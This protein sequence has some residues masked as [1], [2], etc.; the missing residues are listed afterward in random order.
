ML[1]FRAIVGFTLIELLI[2]ILLM[3]LSVS[4][5]GPSLFNQ[6][7]KSKKEV[8]IAQIEKQLRYISQ[9]AFYSRTIHSVLFSGKQM[10][11]FERAPLSSQWQ[12]LL[13]NRDDVTLEALLE[14]AELV[15]QFDDVFFQ[16][17]YVQFNQMGMP[18][19]DIVRVVLNEEESQLVL[20]KVF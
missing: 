10:F 17:T 15:R 8:T 1:R 14:Q 3:T 13:V 16:P 6:I 19:T 5:V 9:R 4:L 7:E 12:E 11:V 18:D 20:P 2:V